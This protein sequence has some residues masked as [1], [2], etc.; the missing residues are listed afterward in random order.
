[1]ID[2]Q[3]IIECLQTIGIINKMLKNISIIRLKNSE[4]YVKYIEML[5]SFHNMLLPHGQR[6]FE[7]SNNNM[8]EEDNSCD[9]IIV[10]FVNC[11]RTITN[12]INNAKRNLGRLKKDGR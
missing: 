6:I 2:N 11:H 7:Y 8:E 12:R 3:I 5:N 4:D 1:M 9:A 10:L